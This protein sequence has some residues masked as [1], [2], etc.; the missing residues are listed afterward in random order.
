MY[1][2]RHFTESDPQRVGAFIVRHPFG[3]LVTWDG[4]KP[5]ASHLLMLLQEPADAP[6]C[7]I[8]H[9]ARANPQWESFDPAREVMAIFQGAHTYVSAAWYSAPSAPTWNYSAAHV[10]GTPSI[11]SGRAELYGLLRELV[12]SQ[13][14]ASPEAER[15]RLQSMPQPLVDGMMA[16]IV[17]FRITVTRVE[18]VAKLSQNRN[19]ADHARIIEQLRK[20]GDA[21]SLSVAREMEKRGPGR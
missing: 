3:T 7:L 18:A 10:Y 20:R 14:A 2:P 15:Y 6:R 1:V 4:Q 12:D 8:G 21:D 11:V 19:E 5:V 16:A 13:E 17:G 9:M